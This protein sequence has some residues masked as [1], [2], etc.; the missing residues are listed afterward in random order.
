MVL[1][2]FELDEVYPTYGSLF[3]WLALICVMVDK[4][5]SPSLAKIFLGKKDDFQQTCQTMV[6]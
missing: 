2:D 6:H 3:V 1:I 4:N 5:P